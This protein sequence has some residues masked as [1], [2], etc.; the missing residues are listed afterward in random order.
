MQ[1]GS[2]TKG[3]RGEDDV[4][5][6]SMPSSDKPNSE[7]QPVKGLNYSASH[8]VD[9]WGHW[10]HRLTVSQSTSCFHKGRVR[11]PECERT[12]TKS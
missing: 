3:R 2:N 10:S 4:K 6:A 11:G 5:L 1:Q 8:N 9:N 12:S 7:F